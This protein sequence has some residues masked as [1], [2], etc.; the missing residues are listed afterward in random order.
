MAF[1]AEA[2]SGL[3]GGPA[4][5]VK[6]EKSSGESPSLELFSLLSYPMFAPVRFVG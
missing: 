6:N 5:V 1:A 4:V 2:L 3:L